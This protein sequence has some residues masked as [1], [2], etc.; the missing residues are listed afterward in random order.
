MRMRSVSP[1]EKF[2]KVTPIDDALVRQHV[3]AVTDSLSALAHRFYGD[4]MLWRVIADRNEIADVRQIVPGAVLII[5]RK[6][7]EKGRYESA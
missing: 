6:P 7:L 1:F 2:G 5:P 3:F 4:W